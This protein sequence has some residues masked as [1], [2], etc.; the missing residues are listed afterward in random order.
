MVRYPVT[1]RYRRTL[2]FVFTLG[3]SRKSV[4]L[5]TFESSARLHPACGGVRSA[6]L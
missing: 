6:R 5:L 1:R 3:Y 2:L 4:R